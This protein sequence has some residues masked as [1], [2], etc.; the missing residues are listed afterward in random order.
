MPIK[1]VLQGLVTVRNG[2]ILIET[3]QAMKQCF[4]ECDVP[5]AESLYVIQAT[6]FHSVFE[7]C[8]TFKFFPNPHMPQEEQLNREAVGFTCF[9][10]MF[11]IEQPLDKLRSKLA[12]IFP[13]NTC[14]LLYYRPQTVR[15]LVSSACILPGKMH[16]LPCL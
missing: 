4:F 1:I 16:V 12:I 2:R 9:H 5:A 6:G 3:V 10:Q 14:V 13:V 8:K 15:C 7:R 11:F